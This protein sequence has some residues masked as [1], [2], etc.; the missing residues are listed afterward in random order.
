V[1]SAFVAAGRSAVAFD[2][3]GTGRSTPSLDCPE[4]GGLVQLAQLRSPTQCEGAAARLDDLA[5]DL[6]DYNNLENAAD[7]NALRGLLGYSRVDI[8]ATRR[9]LVRPLLLW[10]RYPR[11]LRRVVLAAPAPPGEHIISECRRQL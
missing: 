1:F 8:Y 2:Y 5:Y 3:R 10:A 4:T 7:F 6:A 9:V 11:S